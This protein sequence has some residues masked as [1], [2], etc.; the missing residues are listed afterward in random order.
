MP[1]TTKVGV[2]IA[3]CWTK[4]NAAPRHRV[5]W[6][7][8]SMHIFALPPTDKGVGS[9]AMHF[10]DLRFDLDEGI[11]GLPTR[12]ERRNWRSFRH[13]PRRVQRTNA[14]AGQLTGR[15][16]RRIICSRV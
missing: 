12:R 13:V 7:S 9:K 16:A 5:K 15:A 1:D 14:L 10:A 4:D 11:A 8:D 3:H 6:F 2:E